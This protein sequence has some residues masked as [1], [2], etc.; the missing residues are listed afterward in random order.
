M[1]VHVCK[2]TEAMCKAAAALFVACVEEKPNAVLGLAP[3]HP[4]SYR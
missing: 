3:D 2:S 4:Q 1:K